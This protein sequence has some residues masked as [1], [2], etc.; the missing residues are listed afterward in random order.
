[1]FFTFLSFF[2]PLSAQEQVDSAYMSRVEQMMDSLEREER[3]K[4]VVANYERRM[5]HEEMQFRPIES[6]RL[7]SGVLNTALDTKFNKMEATFLFRDFEAQD[8]VPAMLPAFTAW[9]LKLAGM[10]SRS[11][12]RRMLVANLLAF[13]LTS[14]V[15]HGLKNI[16]HERRPNG[17]DDHSFPSGHS[18][19]AFASATILDREY[20]QRSPWISVGGYA[21]A[22]AVELLRL[23]HHAHHINDVVTGAGIGVVATNLA[24]FITDRFFGERGINR[25]RVMV[26]DVVRLGRFLE[27]PI[28]LSLQSGVEYGR[29]ELSRSFAPDG[30]RLKTSTAF[31][32]S[33]EYSYFFDSRWAA[34]AILRLSTC[35]VKPTGCVDNMAAT[36]SR[37]TV[38]D[39]LNQYHTDVALKYSLPIG[40]EHRASVR[41]LG[42]GRFQEP[43]SFVI[44]G[45][46]FDLPSRSDFECGAGLSLEFLSTKK[47][48]VGFSADYIHAFSSLQPH[49]WYLS[50]AWR[51]LL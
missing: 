13:A 38:G 27:R 9:T 46:S 50:S 51:I 33:L 16:V 25:P 10:E 49:R 24:Y 5:L 8:Y 2:L 39:M 22:T 11:K 18:S 30:V 1:M 7:L 41:L 20:G 19:L 3:A 17:E 47:Y 37:E 42:G 6:V 14:G 29:H 12:T 35:E 4:Q 44:D 36:G 28:S 40:L 15:T 23:R 48:V 34:E 43:S 32:T 26:G 21:S 45:L 31:S